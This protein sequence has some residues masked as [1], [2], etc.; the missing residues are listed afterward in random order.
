MRGRLHRRV[1]SFLYLCPQA[2]EWQWTYEG[3]H[4]GE[5]T[6]DLHVPR[7]AIEAGR[8]KAISKLFSNADTLLVPLRVL[9]TLQDSASRAC[10]VTDFGDEYYI[11]SLLGGFPAHQIVEQLLIRQLQQL[12]KLPLLLGVQFIV[13]ACK[14]ILQQQ[15]E[16]KHPT[17]ASPSEA[18]AL[19][20]HPK[21]PI[22]FAK[23]HVHQE[24]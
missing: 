20:T 21:H 24:S 16:L 23:D 14:K 3:K 18:C 10:D 13:A 1:I 19:T 2:K 6:E 22:F 12:H 15:I 5:F 8:V 11:F 9:R 7:H 4:L 17:P